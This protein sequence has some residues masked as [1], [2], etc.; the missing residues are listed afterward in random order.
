MTIVS[1]AVATTACLPRI[2]SSE[3][4]VRETAL[5]RP[6]PA[7]RLRATVRRPARPARAPTGRHDTAACPERSRGWSASPAPD[8]SPGPP[9]RGRSTSCLDDKP[10]RLPAP[11]NRNSRARSMSCLAPAGWSG[12]GGP[13]CR[14][15]A[16]HVT[17]L[18]VSMALA[19]A[20][21][22]VIAIVLSQPS[23]SERAS[24][25][26]AGRRRARGSAT[27]RT[28]VERI[29]Q[30]DVLVVHR[31]AVP[32]CVLVVGVADDGG[33]SWRPPVRA[34]LR[35]TLSNRD[36][37][38]MLGHELQQYDESSIRIRSSCRRASCRADTAGRGHC[39]AGFAVRCDS[40]SRCADCRCSADSPRECGS[41][42]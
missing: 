4:G 30:G 11:S 14:C 25:R 41:T 10:R 27:F 20:D 5:A 28:L 3:R 29:N 34:S 33:D 36:A 31:R 7:W 2:W 18:V 17:A 9:S 24:R 19:V 22:H 37:V 1:S 23:P 13:R 12:G 8:C 38:A 26:L 16:T 15:S 21:W 35:R 40:A 6:A 42:R 32:T 39:S